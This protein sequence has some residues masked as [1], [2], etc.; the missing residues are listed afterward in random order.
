VI[1]RLRK[2]FRHRIDD[3]LR[4]DAKRHHGL[5]EGERLGL[6]EL[7][8]QAVEGSLAALAEAAEQAAVSPPS[9]RS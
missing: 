3:Q 5:S 1:E 2:Q 6:E 4:R 8:R 7:L 9:P